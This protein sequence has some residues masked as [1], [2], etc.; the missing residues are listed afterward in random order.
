MSTTLYLQLSALMF[1]EY[2]VWGAWLPVLAARLLGPLQMSGKQTG[3]I[4]ATLPLASMISPLI[5]GQLAD[6]YVDTRWIL[7]ACHALGVVLLFVAARTSKFKP[8]FLVMLGYSM[9]YAATIPL[10]NSLMFSHLTDAGKQ[11]PGIFIWA[12][13][14]WAL[15]GYALTGWRNFRKAE[16]DGSDC[17][18]FAAILSVVMAI[19]CV[20]QPATPPKGGEGVPMFKALSMLSDPTFAVFIIASVVVAGVM[21]FY[22]LGT[23]QF[24]QDIGASS[25][26]VPAIMGIAQ[27]AQSLATLFLLGLFLTKLGSKW[28]LTLGAACWAL[29][30]VFYTVKAPKTVVA[31]AQ[32]FHGL[33]YVFFIIGGQIYVNTVAKPEIVSSAQGLIILAT[34]GIG[35]FLGS[36]VAGVVM[37]RSCVAGKFNWSKVFLVPLL[38]TAAGVL[39]LLV[40]KF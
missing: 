39:A 19:V 27:A 8:L 24:L 40:L 29:M 9:L 33:A 28:T 6:K 17:L 7:A 10:V 2:A 1:L 12:P 35:M 25:K 15:V 38:C 18:K 23:A 30:Y 31:A 4:Y 34:S 13:V 37:D 36:Q 26:N 3:W 21:Q 11:S 20:I 14:A 22:F 32:V 16:G 5:A